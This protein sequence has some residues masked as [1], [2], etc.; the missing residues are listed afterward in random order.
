MNRSSRFVIGIDLGTTNSTLSYIDTESGPEIKTF[1]IPQLVEA[2]EIKS[3]TALPSFLY[4]PGE[5]ELPP[6][7]MALPWDKD[8]N[9]IV[10]LPLQGT[11]VPSNLVFSAK[12]WLSY[13]R[14]DREGP[15][16]PWG[17]ATSAKRVSPVEA[18]ARYLLHMKEAWNYLMAA[19]PAPWHPP[20]AAGDEKRFLATEKNKAS[21][22]Q[23]IRSRP[24]GTPR[25]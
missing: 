9:S 21:R 13:N 24:V 4:L 20:A 6:G 15:I 14:V 5:Y 8:S 22:V 2:G 12:S 3:L 16:L 1:A 11:R 25:L 18:S 17:K 23:V 7:S 10:G 19:N